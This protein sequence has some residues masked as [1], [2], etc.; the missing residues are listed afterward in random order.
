MIHYRCRVCGESRINQALTDG[1]PPDDWDKVI[2][3]P[4]VQ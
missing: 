3:L 2:A 4:G 1:D